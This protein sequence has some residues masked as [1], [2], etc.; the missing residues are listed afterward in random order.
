MLKIVGDIEYY[1][2]LSTLKSIN[3]ESNGYGKT[4]GELLH[5]PGRRAWA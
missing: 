4:S 3:Y 5:H 2:Y 1:A